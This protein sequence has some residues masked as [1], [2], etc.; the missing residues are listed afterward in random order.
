M[1]IRHY[2][3][4]FVTIRYLRLFAIRVFQT[5]HVGRLAIQVEEAEAQNIKDLYDTTSKL[6]ARYNQTEKPIKD[7]QGKTLT[8]TEEQLERWGER[9]NELLN[10]PAPE[11]LP[12][13]P[14]PAAVLPTKSGKPPRLEIKE[15]IFIKTLKNGMA[16]G[17]DGVPAKALK[18]DITTTTEILCKLS[19]GNLGEGSSKGLERG[20]PCEIT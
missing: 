15:A 9:F 5:P 12:D 19:W 18:V 16:S 17:L 1:T 11:D 20:T 3:P 4:L 13:I 8:T 6:A 10:R 2:S 14:P 7:K